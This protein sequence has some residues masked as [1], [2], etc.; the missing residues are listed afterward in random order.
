ME[1]RHLPTHSLFQK[2]FLVLFLAV[3]VP[4]AVNGVSEAWL[5]YRDQRARLG[6]LLGVEA[7]S[8]A[9]RIESFT[10]EIANQLGWLA[11]LPW[12]E[13]PDER[14]RVDA[15]RLLRQSP[16]IVSLTLV[17]GSG[18]ERIYVSR[19]G[20]N[21]TESGIDRSADPAVAGARSA[22][23]WYGEVSYFRGSEPYVTVA[24]SGN[25]PS[26]G[27][28]VAEV[29]LKLI[30]DVISA[31]KVGET[32]H[33]FVVDDADRLVAHPDISLV[34]RGAD[35]TTL[36]PF[37]AIRDDVRRAGK[38]LA[39]THDAKG[40]AI[41]AAAA[42]VA[43]PEWTVIVTQPLSEAFAP[44][45]QALW[46]TGALLLASGAFAGVLAYALARRMTEPIRRLEEGTER[47]GAGQFDYRIDIKTGDELQ[48]LADSFNAMAAE[49]AVSQER[50][51]RIA[52]LKRF[53]APQVAELV[54]RK[55]DDGVL[56][57]RRSEVVAVFSDLR[58]FTAFSVRATPEEVMNVLSAYYE[59]LGQI[60]TAY[61]ATLTSFSGDGLM[62]LVNA[63][64]PVEDP[65]RV[66]VDM[67]VE[68]QQS[69][70][71]LILGWRDQGHRIGFGVGLALGPAT[72]GRIGYEDR[73]DYT[74]IGSVVNLAA[75]LCASAADREILM[76]AEV[77]KAVGETRAIT[78][79]GS[80]AIKGY[81]EELPVFGIRVDAQSGSAGWPEQPG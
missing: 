53:L 72:V 29:N 7:E 51:E 22:R 42:A 66:A 64:V 62:V 59:A 55:G 35:E 74:A 43:S 70:Q 81:D 6:E 49:L 58:G 23:I 14:R 68:M 28:M 45:Y 37:R 75:R 33:A 3:V 79:L 46:R 69:V 18:R 38:G 16:A 61:A 27:V 48:R 76:D 41:A 56:E 63:P 25:R 1:G 5:G 73:F 60:I 34:L 20:L 2:Y 10:A 71:S 50:Q 26:I 4:L 77:A 24:I 8:A 11:Q 15:L 9:G 19:I 17:D 30:W 54:D 31:I 36:A 67:A 13:E 40:T 39:T 78:P 57:G 47:I 80:L 44:I 32:G 12:T 65:A 21:R 52:K